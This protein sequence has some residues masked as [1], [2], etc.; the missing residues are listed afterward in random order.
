[1]HKTGGN[2]RKAQG[3][4][5]DPMPRDV[6]LS[7]KLSKTLRHK[8]AEQNI[9]MRSDGYVLVSTL[10][11]HREYKGFTLEEIK[12]VVA[13][14]DKQRYCLAEEDGQLWIRANQ[15]HSVKVDVA[16]TPI[17]SANEVPI[18]VHGT[19]KRYWPM[20]REK[21]LSVMNRNHIH[22]APG[23]PKHDGVISGM[24]ASSELYIYINMK[25]A[26]DDGMPFY[27]SAN[28]VILT[29]G[30]NGFIPVKYFSQVLTA[31]NPK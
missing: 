14:S 28:N 20:I 31:T 13:N 26:L 2:A 17:Q 7:R 22:L 9:P 24:R 18:A 12:E 11:G 29:P 23:L 1:M 16:M 25:L 5:R 15:G 19:Y 4:P 30:F 8:A 27:R 3:R 10:L 6:Q 21:G